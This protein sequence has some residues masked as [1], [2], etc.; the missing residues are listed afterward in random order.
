LSNQNTIPPTNSMKFHYK[1]QMFMNFRTKMFIWFIRFTFLL[2]PYKM[3]IFLETF[4][5]RLS[6]WCQPTCNFVGKLRHNIKH[7]WSVWAF[8]DHVLWRLIMQFNDASFCMSWASIRLFFS[9]FVCVTFFIY[10]GVNFD[11][12]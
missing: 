8:P 4:A 10:Y 2:N 7:L 1:Q 11:V 9:C 6:F 12:R 5:K 3:K